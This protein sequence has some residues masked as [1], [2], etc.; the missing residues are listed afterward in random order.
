[1]TMH[2]KG[3]ENVRLSRIINISPPLMWFVQVPSCTWVQT[4]VYRNPWFH[5][6][7]N[8]LTTFHFVTI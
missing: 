6:I 7:F 5:F 8:F 3:M 4:K 1:V 2:R